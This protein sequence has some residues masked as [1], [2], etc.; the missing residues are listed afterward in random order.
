MSVWRSQDFLP[1]MS[2]GDGGDCTRSAWCEGPLDALT[3]AAG[4]LDWL[5]TL[6]TGQGSWFGDR[7]G[8]ANE[9]PHLPGL[10]SGTADTRVQAH[11]RWTVLL[12]RD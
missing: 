5:G 8:L 10:A 9:T 11:G 4:F 7:V 1:W 12:A 6:L 2:S 3:E